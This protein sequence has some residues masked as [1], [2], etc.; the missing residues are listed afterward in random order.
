MN[1]QIDKLTKKKGVAL[2]GFKA[3]LNEVLHDT[4]TELEECTIGLSRILASNGYWEIEIKFTH[5]KPNSTYKTHET[6]YFYIGGYGAYYIVSR[7][8]RFSTVMTP[9][10][11]LRK[12][13]RK[14]DENTQIRR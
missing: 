12:G 5:K 6:R 10:E 11:V 4:Y 7:N 2:E 14:S 3:Y 1:N 13:K 9:E 8:N